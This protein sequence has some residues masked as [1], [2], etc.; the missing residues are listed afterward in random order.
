MKVEDA[1]KVVATVLPKRLNDVQVLVFRL[2]WE[3]KSFAEIAAEGDYDSAYVRD[4]GYKLW[5]MLSQRLGEKVKKSNLQSVIWHHAQILDRL[6]NLDEFQDAVGYSNGSRESRPNL[7]RRQNQIVPELTHDRGETSNVLDFKAQPR[8]HRDWGNA[9]DTST[10]QGRDQELKNFKQWI[11]GDRGCRL[12]GVFGIGGIGK[13]AFTVKLAEQVQDEFEYSI[14]RSLRHAPPLGEILDDLIRFLSDGQDT[15]IPANIHGKIS[16]LVAYLLKQRCLIVLDNFESVLQSG[17]TT[18][19]YREGYEGY[20]ELLRL[21][22]EVGHQSCLIITSREQPQEIS[23]QNDRSIVRSHQLHGLQAE[24]QTIFAD[25]MADS[26]AGTDLIDY[27]RGNPLA[28]QVVSRS[29]Q[30]LFN[31]DIEAFVAQRAVVFNGIRDLLE[32]QCS[33]LSPLEIR[34]MYWLAI[35]REPITLDQ[36]SADM[37]PIASKSSLLETLSSLGWRSLIEKNASGFT[38]QPVVMEYITDRLVEQAYSSIVNAEVTFLTSYALVKKQS[39]EHIREAQMESILQPLVAKLLSDSGN[40][41]K[42][43]D[44]LSQL[45]HKLREQNALPGYGSENILS[46]IKQLKR[47][48]NAVAELPKVTDLTDLHLLHRLLTSNRSGGLLTDRQMIWT[49]HL[50]LNSKDNYRDWIEGALAEFQHDL[51][52]QSQMRKCYR[53]QLHDH[54]LAEIDIELEAVQIINSVGESDRCMFGVYQRSQNY[55]SLTTA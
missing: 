48:G 51:Q 18:G 41:H 44:R 27:Y 21:V 13:T 1:L 26:E 9:P 34:V 46:V 42:L 20:G 38:Q 6:Q 29:I 47:G 55:R 33:R 32:Q 4:V 45:L 54:Q 10:F 17:E 25:G 5:Q 50:G 22:G 39:K 28:L 49:N 35:N 24:A 30:E 7:S 2:T 15:H 31:G 19:H 53:A 23:S 16:L 14:W 37:I 3:G 8:S 11:V 12:A 36:L 43:H 40:W 52:Q